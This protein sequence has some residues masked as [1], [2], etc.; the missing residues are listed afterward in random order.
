MQ[1]GVFKVFKKQPVAGRNM[2][3]YGYY[4]EMSVLP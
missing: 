3:Q 4:F 1:L 2:T